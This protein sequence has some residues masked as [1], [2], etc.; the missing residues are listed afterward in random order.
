MVGTKDNNMHY[1]YISY[2]YNFNWRQRTI[3]SPWY[4]IFYFVSSILNVTFLNTQ[5]YIHPILYLPGKWVALSVDDVKPEVIIW[6]YIR[7]FSV[8]M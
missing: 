7:S 8:V 5:I 4:D 3:V 1:V 6:I 2:D